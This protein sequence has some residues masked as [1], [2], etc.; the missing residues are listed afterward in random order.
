VADRRNKVVVV[1]LEVP[2]GFSA[3][4]EF[5]TSRY[6]LNISRRILATDPRRLLTV[7]F[8]RSRGPKYLL[9][10]AYSGPKPSDYQ[11]R[12]SP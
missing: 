11:Q 1:H 6:S 5:C 3:S 10:L 7:A 4:C 9:I 8:I 12:G 2:V